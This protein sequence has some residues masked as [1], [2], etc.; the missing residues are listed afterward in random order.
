MAKKCVKTFIK[1]GQEIKKESLKPNGI[2]AV[3]Y[4]LP[5]EI[6]ARY[7]TVQEQWGLVQTD[8]DGMIV[9]TWNVDIHNAM[10]S[11]ENHQP[12]FDSL[13]FFR[14]SAMERQFIESYDRWILDHI[15]FTERLENTEADMVALESRFTHKLSY[16][17]HRIAD[18]IINKFK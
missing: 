8:K 10:D 18:W 3:R 12:W 4:A 5:A 17:L 7:G 1:R 14:S 11:T 9:R 15:H 16:P 2:Y 13:T 6:A